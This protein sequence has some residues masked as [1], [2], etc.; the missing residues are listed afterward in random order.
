[1]VVDQK[2]FRLAAR[3]G[4]PEFLPFNRAVVIPKRG[5]PLHAC[6]SKDLG[7]HDALISRVHQLVGPVHPLAMAAQAFV[8]IEPVGLDRIDDR[9]EWPIVQAVQ[10]TVLV[11]EVR[12][13]CFATP[14]FKPGPPLLSEKL[15]PPW[16]QAVTQ[17][18]RYEWC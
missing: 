5:N 16:S 10:L 18:E 14:N 12:E 8:V 1:M 7:G 9:I 11:N 4:D 2:G 13:V 15:D 6:N 17:Y 3:A